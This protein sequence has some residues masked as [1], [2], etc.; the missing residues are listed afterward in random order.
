MTIYDKLRD[1]LK[2]IIKQENLDTKNIKI[3]SKSLTAEEAI[4]NTKRKDFPI[5]NG[6][7]IMLVAQL[8]DE[9]GQA[10]TSAPCQFEGTLDEI[11]NLDINNN[12]YNKG[13]FI[14]S[15]NAV[16]KHLGKCD[17][18]IHCKNDEP[19]KCAEKFLSHLKEN[20]PNKKI[21]LVGFQPSIL[22][23]IKDDFELRVL[24]LNEEVVGTKRYGVLIE[25]GIDDFND[26]VNWC[27]IILCTGSTICNGSIVN[28]LNLNKDVYFY[29]T[30]IAGSAPIL[31]IKRLCF[32]GK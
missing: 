11:L 14:A 9:I 24:D 26:A 22:E 20:M 18:T 8:D 27:D 15:L 7:E 28:F 17:K 23:H 13:L 5:L 2:K 31:G 12:Q 1:E 21:L 29:G 25:N 3:T 32:F 6:K 19:E 10:F 30:T 16:M 4:G